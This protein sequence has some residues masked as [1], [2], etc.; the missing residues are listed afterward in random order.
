MTKLKFLV[1]LLLALGLVACNGDED[2]DKKDDYTLK[3]DS[4][5]DIEAGG[6]FSVDVKAT[7]GT[8]FPVEVKLYKGDALVTKVTMR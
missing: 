6:D 3:V 1:S 2:E 7:V 5:S 8:A 4:I